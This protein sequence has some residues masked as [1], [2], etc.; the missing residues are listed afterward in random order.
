M[1]L[2]PT[3]KRHSAS[4]INSFLGYRSA[5]YLNKICGIRVPV[6]GAAHRGT[7]IEAGINHYIENDD[8][9]IE[10][11]IKHALEVFEKESLGCTPDFDMRQSVGPCV[12]AGIKSFEDRGYLLDPPTLQAEINTMLPGCNV[13]LY[14]K[15]DYLFN[16]RVVDNKVVSKTPKSLKQDYVVQGAIYRFATK[17]PVYFHFIVPQKTGIKIVEIKLTDEEY[18]KGLELASLAAQSIETIFEN[19]PS[20]DGE[21]LKALFFSSPEKLWSYDEKV[22]HSDFFGTPMMAASSDD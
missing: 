16:D 14:G 11:C 15:L 22:V 18:K 1:S 20:M 8:I 19:L 7:A 9:S 3:L 10:D 17:L 4:A 21:L 6:G 2:F 12:I 5:W 13:N